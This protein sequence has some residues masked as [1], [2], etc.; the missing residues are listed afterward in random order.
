MIG[1]IGI[2]TLI[3][4][5]AITS[6]FALARDTQEQEK[7][8]LKEKLDYGTNS[9]TFSPFT[10]MDYGV[11]IGLSYEKIF[12]GNKQ[13][14]LILP[15][16]LMLD[17]KNSPVYRYNDSGFNAS[18][19]FTPGLKIYPFGQSRL[20]YAFGPSFML[21]YG[22]RSSVWYTGFP[23]EGAEVSWLR[24]GVMVSNYL[25]FQV[26]RFL[27]FGLEMGLGV[28]FMDKHSYTEPG[29]TN[30]V[31]LNGSGKPTGRFALTIGFR[32]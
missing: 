4:T 32:F 31:T 27:N 26:T 23:V 9:I 17:G 5:M 20:T 18:I 6:S 16:S 21:N 30:P 25:N 12:G 15:F 24:M 19:Y 22:R 8:P 14:G 13:L 7:Y 2:F 10:V 3:T 1:K 29:M 11:G 28:R